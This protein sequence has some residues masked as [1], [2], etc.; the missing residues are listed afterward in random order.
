MAKST[1]QFARALLELARCPQLTLLTCIV[2]PSEQ[3]SARML[4]DQ[5]AKGM[6][7]NAQGQAG[8]LT[9]TTQVC[10]DREGKARMTG[11]G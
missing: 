9:V 11:R 7:A 8:L 2:S 4:L 6:G 10:G 3:D 5:L 1:L